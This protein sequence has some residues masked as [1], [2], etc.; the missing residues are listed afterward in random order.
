MNSKF[1]FLILIVIALGLVTFLTRDIEPN[2]NQ[3]SK[4]INYESFSN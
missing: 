2:K 1:T 4:T 3:I